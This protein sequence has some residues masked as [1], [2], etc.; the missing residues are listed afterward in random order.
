MMFGAT[1]AGAGA[2]AGVVALPSKGPGG[3]PSAALT[4][5]QVLRP[6]LDTSDLSD[7]TVQHSMLSALNQMFLVGATH[8]HPCKASLWGVREAPVAGCRFPAPAPFSL[9]QK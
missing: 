3:V 4:A 2:G 7:A 8:P 6:G 5:L 1:P 9:L